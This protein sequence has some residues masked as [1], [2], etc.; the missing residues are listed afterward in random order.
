MCLPFVVPV[1]GNERGTRLVLPAE[2]NLRV[3]VADLHPAFGTKDVHALSLGRPAEPVAQ[4]T[5]NLGPVCI[6]I[7]GVLRIRR[8][9]IRR[10]AL[11]MQAAAAIRGA[12]MLLLSEQ[13][14]HRIQGMD[15]GVA[16]VGRAI[17]P[18]PVPVIVE[19][20]LV[21]RT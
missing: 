10:S 4:V 5:M 7:R 19:M 2:V 11:F 1:V 17:F 8:R 12:R 13:P 15:P 3:V 21:E 18:E 16:K 14:A 6:S 20:I 9:L